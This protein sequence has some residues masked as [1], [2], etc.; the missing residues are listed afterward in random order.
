MKLLGGAETCIDHDNHADGRVRALLCRLY[1][2]GLGMSKKVSWFWKARLSTTW[3]MRPSSL[4]K[5]VS[6]KQPSSIAK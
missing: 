3:N 5:D 4:V 2:V 6:I 1:N